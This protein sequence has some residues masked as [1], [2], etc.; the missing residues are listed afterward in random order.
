[1]S[2]FNIFATNFAVCCLAVWDIDINV[3]DTKKKSIYDLFLPQI[4]KHTQENELFTVKKFFAW[5]A[6][7]ILQSLFMYGIP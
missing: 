7:S 5:S 3:D 4:Y 1:M 6:V 2:G